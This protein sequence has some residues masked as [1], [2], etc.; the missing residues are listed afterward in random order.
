MKKKSHWANEVI[1]LKKLFLLIL[2]LLVLPCLALAEPMPLE[3]AELFS[4]DLREDGSRLIRVEGSAPLLVL[5]K[6]AEVPADLPEGTVVLRRPV[7][8]LLVTFTN[9]MSLIEAV[10]ALDAVRLTTY[11][12]DS[13][14]LP[15]TA[16]AMK[17]G[18][19]LYCGS[20]KSPDWELVLAE[21]TR[22]AVFNSQLDEQPEVR[23]KL[24]ELGIP[25]LYDLSSHEA[26]PMGRLEWIRLYGV[27]LD[28]ENEAEQIFREQQAL[29][30]E[31]QPA[32][33]SKTV[34]F[35]H[36]ASDG[37]LYVRCAGDYMNAMLSRAGGV[38]AA[39]DFWPDTTG[40]KAMEAEA[41]FA[42]A[43][44]ADVLVYCWSFGGKPQTQAELLERCPLLAECKAVQSGSLWCTSPDWYQSSAEMGTMIRDMALML[45]GGTPVHLVRLP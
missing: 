10:D 32:G 22:L 43:R 9:A 16:D 21:G 17:Q 36:V 34:L 1:C 15:G 11:D 18:S 40:S 27:L 38:N 13:W 37:S 8:R 29:V 7:D 24:E 25:V 39:A 14:Y 2:A 5:D 30:G 19:L 3:E 28:R 4:V 45:S 41:F 6:E 31:L 42:L 12:L 23:Q 20:W 26:S 44:E 35:F 33:E